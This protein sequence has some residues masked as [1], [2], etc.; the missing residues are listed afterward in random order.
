[1]PQAPLCRFGL[2]PVFGAL[3]AALAAPAPAPA[4]DL[5]AQLF[6]GFA[7]PPPVTVLPPAGRE[8]ARSAARQSRGAA[9][10]H[11]VRTCDGRHFPLAN[12]KGD[13][14][15]EACRNLCPASETKVFYGTSIDRA[16]SAQG[17]RYTQL[18]NAYRYRDELVA[19]CTCNGEPAGGLA[20]I[21]VDADPTIRKGDIV[22]R[23]DGPMV[24]GRSAGRRITSLNFSPA[25]PALAARLARAP[26][27]AAD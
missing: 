16:L 4:Q 12:G 8:A 6:G 18:A 11:C 15:L 23:A 5:F 25:P 27:M 7:F 19:G 26:V 1:M 20:R 14:R 17:Q 13:T 10:A 21:D 22:V 3:L 2:A 24:A 9:Q